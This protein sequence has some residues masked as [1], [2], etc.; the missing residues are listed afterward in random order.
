[1][2]FL[3]LP[4]SALLGVPHFAVGFAGRTQVSCKVAAIRL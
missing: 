2:A 1:M 4:A 3:R